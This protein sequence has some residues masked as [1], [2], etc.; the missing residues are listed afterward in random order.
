MIFIHT[1]V[2]LYNIEVAYIQVLITHEFKKY[3]FTLMHSATSEKFQLE[4]E[5]KSIVQV[6][7]SNV[8]EEGKT[9][10]DLCD[11]TFFKNSC[12]KSQR[13]PVHMRRES[14]A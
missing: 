10:F 1:P 2:F 6:A 13:I 14:I 9:M 12:C 4:E 3:I 5:K 11:L 7:E 8:W